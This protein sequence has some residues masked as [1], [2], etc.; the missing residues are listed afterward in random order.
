MCIGDSFLT[1][2]EGGRIKLFRKFPNYCKGS[3]INIME[4]GGREEEGEG[5]GGKRQGNCGKHD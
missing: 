1:G 5:R 2:A 3:A 4:E